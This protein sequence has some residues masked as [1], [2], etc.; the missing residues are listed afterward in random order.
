MLAA[1]AFPKMSKNAAFRADCLFFILLGI[2]CNA[3]VQFVQL[4]L[5]NG[6]PLCDFRRAVFKILEDGKKYGLD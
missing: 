1:E 3:A 5:L 4:A 2:S 6:L